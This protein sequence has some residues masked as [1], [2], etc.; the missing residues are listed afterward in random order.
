MKNL[1]T[2]LLAFVLFS[3]MTGCGKDDEKSGCSGVLNNG[4]TLEIDG[5]KLNLSAAQL[6]ISGGFEGDIYLFQVGGL[7]DNCE[8]LKV[9]SFTVE[10][11]TNSNFDGNYTIQGFFGANLN[12]VTSVNI[13]TSNVTSGQQSLIEVSSGSM[14]VN[15]LATREYEVDMSGTLTG[16]GSVDVSFKSKF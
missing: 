10:I 3:V 13:T 9:L 5:E 16:G 4:G 15:K 8:T 2:F 1:C 6:L 14:T 7:T 12:D 11:P